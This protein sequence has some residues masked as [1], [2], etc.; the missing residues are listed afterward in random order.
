MEIVVDIHTHTISSGHAYSTVKEYVDYANKIGLKHFA[1]TDHA[2]NMPGASGYYHFYAMY[3]VPSVI[4]G[5]RVYR[6]IELNILDF[7][8]NVDFK[9]QD[10]DIFEVVIASM[11]PPCIKPGTKEEN[12]KAVTSVMQK[13][14]VKIIGHLG[15]PTY[16]IDIEEICRVAKET[17]TYLEINN[18][19]LEAGGYRND[20]EAIKQL[21]LECKRINHPVIVGSDAHFHEA[22]GDVKNSIDLLKEID[23]PVELIINADIKR[24]EELII[25]ENPRKW[26]TSK[27]RS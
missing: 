20:R 4:E 17:S 25:P 23:F 10:L 6:G 12:T 21:A 27:G 8:G 14:F 15:S 3:A 5:V 19:S 7:D 26:F 13:P 24:F 9:E 11:H 1:V 18:K 22:L 16:P 2:P